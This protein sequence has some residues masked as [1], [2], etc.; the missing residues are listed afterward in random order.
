[1]PTKISS[2]IDR[3]AAT[4]VSLSRNPLGIIALFLVL[5]Y[6]IGSLVLTIPN[7]QIWKHQF[8][9]MV[10]FV[11]FFPLVVLAAFT[12]LVAYRHYHLY[13]PSDF[14]DESLF[15]QS[16]PPTALNRH[17]P[18]GA[19]DEAFQVVVEEVEEDKVHTV[20]NEER[21]FGF[22]LVHQAKV[23]CERTGPG[24]GRYLTRVWVEPI[25]NKRLY[26]IS[27]VTYQL[28]PEFNQNTLSTTDAN[29]NFEVWLNIY[30]EFPIVALIK[31]KD[32]TSRILTRYLDLPGR[33]PD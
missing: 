26:S 17:T 19:V 8:H 3:F 30:G 20:F 28:W 33:P 6:F 2:S 27:H 16:S 14:K 1:M 10:L 5:A 29:A 32:G 15:F 12:F 24:S 11:A 4:A 31:L 22:A 9:P 13:A 25:E 23:T 18:G 21:D 7:E